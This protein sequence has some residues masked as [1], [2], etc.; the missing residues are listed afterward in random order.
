MSKRNIEFQRF[1]P[2]EIRAEDKDDTGPIIEGHAALFNVEA[3][4][5][6]WF[7]EVIRPG[8]FT[9]TIDES[10][11]V[12]F[13]NHNTDMILGRKS[14]GTLQLWADE[15]GLK[16]RNT[17]GNT[18]WGRDSYEAIKRG[19]VVG[20]SFG[21]DVVKEIVTEPKDKNELPLR[22]VLEIRLWEVSPCVFPAYEAT[23]VEARAILDKAQ[24]RTQEPG[25]NANHSAEPGEDAEGE[26]WR[27][28]LAHRRRRLG[29]L[30]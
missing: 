28:H 13:W 30:S 8:A 22:E 26:A 18:S 17:P 20:M 16:I 29:L 12:M 25:T 11:P 3:E 15:T 23:D 19:D 2:L 24:K 6:G 7:R 10:D 27:V 9:K 1:F 5:G 14:S 4:I 21:F